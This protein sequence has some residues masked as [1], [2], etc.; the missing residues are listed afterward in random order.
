MDFKGHQELWNPLSKAA[1][2]KFHG[3]DKHSIYNS[4]QDWN[5][6]NRSE[7][8]QIVLIFNTALSYITAMEMEEGGGC[9]F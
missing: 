9:V 1:L 3:S 2:G 5:N 6:L 8:W 4:L 7:A